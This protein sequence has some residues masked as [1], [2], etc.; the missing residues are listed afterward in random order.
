MD[1]KPAV[2]PISFGSKLS[3]HSEQPKQP[4]ALIS[5]CTSEVVA[6]IEQLTDV[7]KPTITASSR[8]ALVPASTQLHGERASNHH[9]SQ[10]SAYNVALDF[11]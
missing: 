11:G 5:R 1:S 7:L 6:S 8:A 10:K 4:K 3:L 2:F 9:S